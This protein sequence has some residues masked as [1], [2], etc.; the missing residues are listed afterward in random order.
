MNRT[1]DIAETVARAAGES[2]VCPACGAASRRAAAKFCA[3][4][5]RG[6]DD[7]D[8][9]PADHLRASYRW[10]RE[11]A[12]GARHDNPLAAIYEHRPAFVAP[13][14]PRRKVSPRAPST[15]RAPDDYRNA[16][17]ETAFILVAFC[18]IPFLGLL[19]APC[20]V[21]FGCAGLVCARRSSHRRGAR[22]A[23][24]AVAYGVILF[25]AQV[26]ICWA[27]FGATA[28]TF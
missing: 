16:A 7:P 4:C 11:E 23:A 28:R 9:R 12:S 27:L 26:F 2:P 20:A 18:F 24:H 10:R 17:T 14:L 19:L 21:V 5:G 13:H 8:Y 15:K 25:G 6:L 22:A 3:T 1:E